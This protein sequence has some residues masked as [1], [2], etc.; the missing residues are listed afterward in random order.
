MKRLL[1]ILALT[2]AV[3]GAAFAYTGSLTTTDGGLIA[4]GTWADSAHPATVSWNIFYDGDIWDYTYTISVYSKEVSHA[5]IEV[6]PTFTGENLFSPKIDGN[7]WT[8]IGIDD[9]D[10]DNGNPNIPGEVHGLKFDETSG[11]VLALNFRS[12]RAPVWGDFYAKDG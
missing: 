7:A 2:L 3:S 11:T 6:S 5:I 1:T 10:L 12:D 4:T 8:A 9:Y